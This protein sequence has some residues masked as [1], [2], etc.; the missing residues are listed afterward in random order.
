MGNTCVRPGASRRYAARGDDVDD[1]DVYAHGRSD[2]AAAARS[3]P[4][5]HAGEG[6][7]AV[8]SAGP[9][10]MVTGGQDGT[11]AM[12]RWCG[13]GNGRGKAGEI[14]HRWDGHPKPVTRVAY[15]PTH[16]L[17]LTGCRDGVVRAWSCAEPDAA[18]TAFRG[19]TL[20]VSGLAVVEEADLACTGSRDYTVRLWDLHASACVQTSRISRNVVTFVRR[21]PGERSVAQASEDLRVR[22]WDVRDLSGAAQTLEGHVNIPHC[23]D[24]SDDGNYVVSSSN[25]FEDGAGCEVKVWDRRAGKILRELRGHD[26]STNCCA[27]VYDSASRGKVDAAATAAPDGANGAVTSADGGGGFDDI[28]SREGTRDLATRGG[29]GLDGALVVSGSTDRTVRVWDPADG[30]AVA[31]RRFAGYETEHDAGPVMCCAALE[32]F[33][34]SGGEGGA[35]FFAAGDYSGKV[36]VWEVRGRGERT[37]RTTAFTP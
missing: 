37:V 22:I 9:G 25:G 31:S 3:L 14:L 24:V 32:P 5:V 29:G 21:V 33:T 35:S 8:C 13:N 15:S 30:A 1:D 20:T 23:V 16:G 4:P 19:H 28:D 26:M 27:F 36:Q 17:V 34:P 6:V 18:A 12:W 7:S 2:V 11:A 10:V